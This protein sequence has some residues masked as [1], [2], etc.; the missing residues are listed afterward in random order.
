MGIKTA[1]QGQTVY[2]LVIDIYGS[3]NGLVDFL[4]NNSLSLDDDLS[5]EDISFSDDI[6]FDE[7]VPPVVLRSPNRSPWITVQGQ[8]IFDIAIQLYGSF[9]NF[10]DIIKQMSV[11]NGAVE[12]NVSIDLLDTKNVNAI[13]FENNSYVVATFDIYLEIP[14]SFLLLENEAFLLFEDGGRIV[15]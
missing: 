11:P 15:I 12:T 2:D 7:F 3:I 6:V 8:T 4:L 10:S 13:L 1:I 5:G 14:S 9:D